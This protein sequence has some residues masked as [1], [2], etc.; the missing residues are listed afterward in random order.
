VTVKCAGL[1]GTEGY[2][3]ICKCSETQR[4][5]LECGV[6]RKW[7]NVTGE[8]TYRSVERSSTELRSVRNFCTNVGCKFE[9][10]IT[11]SSDGRA[12]G[13]YGKIIIIILL[14]G[15]YIVCSANKHQCYISSFPQKAND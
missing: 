14:K 4:W 2:A 1:D 11:N 5:G 12:G 10:K 15:V 3:H 9:N 8:V 7:L 6:I 13:G